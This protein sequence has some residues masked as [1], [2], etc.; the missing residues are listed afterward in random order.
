VRVDFSSKC[1]VKSIDLDK[2]RPNYLLNSKKC[3]TFAADFVILWHNL[4]AENVN[5]V[6]FLCQN[7]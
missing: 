6:D 7:M 3:T 2:K 5:F 4:Y 1:G